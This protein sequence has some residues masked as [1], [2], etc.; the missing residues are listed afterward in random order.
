MD[1]KKEKFTR[2]NNQIRVPKVVLIKDGKNLGT[3]P[4]EVARKMAFDADLDLVEVSPNSSPPVCSILDY[5]KFKY[6]QQKKK[7]SQ[8]QVQSKEKEITLRYVTSDHDLGT[9]MNHAKELL[10]KGDK[11]KIAIKFKKRENVYKDQGFVVIKKCLEQLS[12]WV[13]ERQPAFEGGQIICRIS[14]KKVSV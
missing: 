1:N 10:E 3:V 5:G 9:K 7:K 14:P 8:R 2:I 4:T 6:D 13:V 12:E 11:I